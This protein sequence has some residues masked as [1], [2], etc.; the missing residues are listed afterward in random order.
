MKQTDKGKKDRKRKKVNKELKK[1][2]IKNAY[3][4]NKKRIDRMYIS[5]WFTG[6]VER[7][8]AFS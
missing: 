6:I 3:K 2:K 5:L 8:I 4:W 1:S 7:H